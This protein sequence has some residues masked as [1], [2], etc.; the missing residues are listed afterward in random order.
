MR[1]DGFGML[2]LVTIPSVGAVLPDDV[3][4][5]F[6]LDGFVKL[7]DAFDAALAARCVDVLWSMLEL[8]RMDPAGWTEPVIRIPGSGHPDLVAAI[9]TPLLVGAIDDLLGGPAAWQ[10]RV[11]GYGSFPVRFPSDT[12][13]GDTGWHIDGSFGE[14]PW[15]R[16]NFESRGRALLLLMLFSDV[17]ELDAPTRFKVGSH[18]DVARALRH[19]E[20]DGIAFLPGVHAPESLDHDTVLATGNAGDVY[21]CHPFL[22][23]AAGWPH[24][25]RQPRF[26]A[27]P[28]IHHR[29]G[30]WLGGF[31]YDDLV[32]DSPV[33]RAVRTYLEPNR[34]STITGL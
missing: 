34:S 4:E 1:R 30:E 3:V 17:T 14:P 2:R 24:R 31:D 26:I 20:S 11:H 28:C 12:D 16:V 27:Q 32:N 15:Y 13:P 19:V 21:L 25:G 10:R 22:V 8:D 5:R 23:H 7:D 6:V 33:K 18:R 29:E 9:N